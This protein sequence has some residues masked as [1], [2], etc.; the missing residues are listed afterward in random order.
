MDVTP[1]NVLRDFQVPQPPSVCSWRK[2]DMAKI[3]F[4]PERTSGPALG[5][6]MLRWDAV[7]QPKSNPLISNE[8][9]S[10][11]SHGKSLISR[12]LS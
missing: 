10:W 7:R 6:P 5:P 8:P 11:G 3:A 9:D 4:G 12:D 2:A 1:F